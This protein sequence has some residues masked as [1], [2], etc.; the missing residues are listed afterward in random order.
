MNEIYDCAA[1][2]F[3]IPARPLL[4]NMKTIAVVPAYNESNYIKE[5]AQRTRRFVDK[6]VV[7]DDGSWD[8]TAEA[9]RAGGA[10]VISYRKN[11]GKAHAMRAGFER[12]RDYDIVVVLDGDLQ[13]APE[14]IPT[15][16]RCVEEGS[17]LCIGSRILGDSGRMPLSRRFSN[18]VAS[19]LVSGLTNKKL[20]DPQSGFRA[21]RRDK[22]DLLE[23]KAERYAIEHIMILEG[24]KKGLRI[25][26]V[27]ISCRYAGEKSEIR[28]IQDTMRVIYYILKFLVSR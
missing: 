28:A 24:S 2:L 9:A 13:H 5:V 21:I 8:K 4:T 25:N 7:V 3:Y 12:C 6:V 22:L 10:E 17:D 15:L 26:E 20:T 27:P 18:W 11:L 19:R 14:E 23:L 1:V 16:L